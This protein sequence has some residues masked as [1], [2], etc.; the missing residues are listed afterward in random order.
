M[1]KARA[2]RVLETWGIYP[3]GGTFKIANQITIMQ[4]KQDII[5]IASALLSSGHYTHL[6]QADREPIL[7]KFDYGK[8]WEKDGAISRFGIMAVE[9]SFDILN[10]IDRQM[11]CLANDEEKL[12]AE[13]LAVLAK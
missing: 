1:D 11:K 4:T 5:K 6:S 8:E 9:D 12:K 7:T 2:H 13:E 10:A 3:K